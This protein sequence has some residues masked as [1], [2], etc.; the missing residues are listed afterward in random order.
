MSSDIGG[1]EAV[2]ESELEADPRRWAGLAVLAGSLLMVVMDMT[3]LNVALPSMAADLRPS[4]TELLWIVDV[5]ALVVAGLLVTTSS[6]GDRWGRRSMLIAGFVV[7]GVAS[8]AVVFAD[9]SGQVIAVRVLLGV[10]GAMIMPSTL[11]LIR[12]LFPDPR[13]RATALGVWG[14]MAAVGAA[15]G[16]IV[17]GALLEAFSW[18]SAFLVNVPVMVVAIVA[19]VILLPNSRSARPPRLDAVGTI[20]SI[21]GMVALMYSIKEFGKHGISTTAVLTL[22][23]AVVLITWFIWHCLRREDP[24]LE[25]RLFRGRTFTAGTVTALTTS[26]GLAAMML[27]GAQWLQLVQGYSPLIAGAA[28]LPAAGFGLVGSLLAPPLAARIGVRSVLALG[29]LSSA[30][31]FFLLFAAPAPLTYLWVAAALSAVGLGMGALAVASAAIM[32]GA[33][34]EK[35]GSAAAVDESSFELGSALGVAILGS[36]AAAAYRSELPAADLAAAGLPTEAVA[37]A[38]ESLAGALEVAALAGPAGDPLAVLARVSFTDS[39]T[40][41]GLAGGVLLTISAVGVWLLTPRDARAV[42]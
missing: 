10:G 33:P 35:S 30:G 25:V 12:H 37:A 13:E 36:V 14:A 38:R 40:A 11:S 34:P 9:T 32:N 20:T 31:G 15:L 39:F 22:V 5:Y 3:I 16:P 4:S 8:A 42:H 27:L 7:F 2:D 17:G 21:A 28:L 18:H 23:A 41:F 1:R 6:L 29:L 19:A 24:L 26:I